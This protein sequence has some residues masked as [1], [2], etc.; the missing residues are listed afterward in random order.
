MKKKKKD[1]K[2][3]EEDNYINRFIAYLAFFL[4][5][6]IVGYLIVGI[7][8]NKSISFNKNKDKEEEE[9]KEVVIDNST[10]L[11]GEIFD[12]KEEEYYVLIYNVNDSDSLFV[13]WLNAYKGK[14]DALTVYIVDSSKKLNANFLVEKDSNTSP[15]GYDD[16]RIKSPTLIKV[17]N[18]NVSLYVEGE[19]DIKN[20]FKN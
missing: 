5:M 4:I 6:L 11:A 8:V 9:E 13:N 7:F 19:E 15:S 3:V 18:K 1:K 10:I 16:L 2:V 12:Q 20:I 17:Q 14:E